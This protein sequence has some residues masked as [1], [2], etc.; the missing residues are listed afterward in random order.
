MVEEGSVA[1][2]GDNRAVLE[3]VWAEVLASMAAVAPEVTMVAVED[4]A[5]HKDGRCFVCRDTFGNKHVFLPQLQTPLIAVVWISNTQL[6]YLLV[7]DEMS[8]FPG[9]RRYVHIDS[10]SHRNIQ[11]NLLLGNS[12]R[13]SGSAI[14]HAIADNLQEEHH[15]A[16][17]SSSTR[18]LFVIP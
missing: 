7:L 6:C 1:L 13:V 14:N 2:L 12:L 3:A 17:V 5:A 15:V 9:C 16:E 18:K 11:N 4:L 10:L 8:P